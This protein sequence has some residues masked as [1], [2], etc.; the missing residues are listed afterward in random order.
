MFRLLVLAAAIGIAYW[1]GY[2]WH[3]VAAWLA[4]TFLSKSMQGGGLIG[5]LQAVG[6]KVIFMLLMM[7]AMY[8][9]KVS[10]LSS[11]GIFLLGVAGLGFNAPTVRL[12]KRMQQGQGRDQS[13]AAHDRLDDAY[14]NGADGDKVRQ[15]EAALTNSL[16]SERERDAD[17]GGGLMSVVKFGMTRK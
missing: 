10:G 16:E 4:W 1:Q 11:I 2:L 5:G 6:L 15:A 8:S 3:V 13:N 9:D 17:N 12:S 7:F 14:S